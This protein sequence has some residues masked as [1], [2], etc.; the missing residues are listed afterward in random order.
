[1]APVRKE[2]MIALWSI[3]HEFIFNRLI[4]ELCY[5]IYVVRLFQRRSGT[6]EETFGDFWRTFKA[7]G[8][9]YGVRVLSIVVI[10]INL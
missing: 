3:D 1:V 6:L 8:N 2:L 9:G 4:V 7:L 5:V 10:T